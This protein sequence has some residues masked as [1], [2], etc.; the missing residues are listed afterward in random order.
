MELPPDDRVTLLPD[1]VAQFDDGF[2]DGSGKSYLDETSLGE[3]ARGNLKE[4]EAGLCLE[5]GIRID[6]EMAREAIT[7]ERCMRTI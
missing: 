2:F 3:R 6:V 4:A 7:L 1:S 5:D